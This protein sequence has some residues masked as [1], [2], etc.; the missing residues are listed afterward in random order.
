[1]GRPV[2]GLALP[3]LPQQGL[4][5]GRAGPPPR[6]RG[7]PRRDRAAGGGR[8]RPGG[9]GSTRC[10]IEAPADAAIGNHV[11][12]P[13][14]HQVLFEESPRPPELLAELHALETVALDPAATRLA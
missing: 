11:N 3:V 2:G 12:D 9:G 10:L 8:R 13:G 1:R 5:P 4:D 14:L 7:L 6:R